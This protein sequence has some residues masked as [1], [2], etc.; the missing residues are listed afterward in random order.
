MSNDYQTVLKQ[1]RNQNRVDACVPVI[2]VRVSI[3]KLG[4]F[5][6]ATVGAG[7]LSPHPL[8]IGFLQLFIS[9]RK[10]GPG[11][12]QERQGQT[13]KK[14]KEISCAR[15]LTDRLADTRERLDLGGRHALCLSNEAC[16]AF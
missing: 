15:G 5:V 4:W 13:K 12:Q 2:S 8:R 1:K 6:S 16:R 11:S 10:E 3:K 7:L 9:L 14:N